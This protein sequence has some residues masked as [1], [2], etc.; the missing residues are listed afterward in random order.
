MI[1]DAVKS[2]NI[3]S[4]GWADEVLEVEF[5]SGAVWQ[6]SP[7]AYG[8]FEEIRDATSIGRAFQSLRNAAA[9]GVVKAS[10][11]TPEVPV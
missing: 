6:Y 10:K 5:N 8:R 3:R 1:R 9:I 7:V 4:L 2:S 11:V